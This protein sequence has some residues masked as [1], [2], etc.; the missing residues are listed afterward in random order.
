M[1]DQSPDV[2]EASIW[3]VTD[4]GGSEVDPSSSRSVTFAGGRVSGQVGVNRFSATY[5]LSE[6]TIHVG[7]VRTTRMAGPP[8][9]MA[10]E[11]KFL[12]GLEGDRPM[13][14]EDD[15]L[16]IGSA[17]IG[18]VLNR[19]A[20]EGRLTLSGTVLY[21]E[22]ILMPVG[23]V[24]IVELLDVSRMDVPADVIASTTIEGASSPPVTFELVTDSA[25]DPTHHY[26]VRAR[27]TGS[28]G[29]LLWTTAAHTDPP[30]D[31]TPLELM[32]VSVGAPA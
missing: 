26:T 10:L 31:G 24:V 18:I 19:S 15:Q 5:S 32:C 14:I 30:S 1:N 22:R 2:L 29:T 13:S 9:Q 20:S 11:S 17:D 25:L 12:A 27:I 21:R 3:V 8:D 23:S 7:P 16:V 4:V 6:G 28:D